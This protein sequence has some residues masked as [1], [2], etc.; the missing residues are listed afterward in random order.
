[1]V[2]GE[3]VAAQTVGLRRGNATTYRFDMCS[4]S[5]DDRYIITT[6][7]ANVNT[8]SI[9]PSDV[10]ALEAAM[11]Q[12]TKVWDATTGAL[13]YNL[14]GHTQDVSVQDDSHS[15]EIVCSPAL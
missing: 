5:L 14:P 4:W 2:T 7:V 9:D 10:A 11:Q 6:Q 15:V 12:R 13:L 1:M 3:A 8:R